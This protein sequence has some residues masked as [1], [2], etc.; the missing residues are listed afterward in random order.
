MATTLIKQGDDDY[1]AFL[2]DRLGENAPLCL[3][4]MGSPSILR[5][6]LL[7]L[8]CSIQCPGSIVIR[9]FDAIRALR[10]A[11][12]VIIGGFHSPME[13]ECLDILLRGQ[14]SMV[15]CAARGLAGLRLGKA[16]RDAIADGRLLVISPFADAVR[17]TT[18]A[19]AVQRNNL[20]AAV[21]DAV[22][23]PHA[24]PNGKTW[25]TVRAALE[26][27]QAVFTFAD[28]GN[29]D[30]IAAGARPFTELD[31]SALSGKRSETEVQERK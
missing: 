14:K 29:G 27:H 9:T 30:L 17:R 1:P 24:A 15:L 13:K 31:A 4:T 6:R 5:H 7:G 12:V 19:H 26:R 23:V 28:D 21:A 22:W 11:G 16:A 10:D 3:Y 20:V 2:K 25:V 8:I 18:A